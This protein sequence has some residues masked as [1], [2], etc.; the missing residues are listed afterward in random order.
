MRTFLGRVTLVLALAMA[1]GCGR[2]ASVPVVAETDAAPN[3][4]EETHKLPFARE[5][6]PV[7]I[8]PTSSLIPPPA[9]LPAGTPVTI[10]LQTALSS[11]SARAGDTFAAVLD[12][13]IIVAGQILAER[14]AV[15]TGRIIE[16]KAAAAMGAPGYLRLALTT[17]FLDGKAVQISSSSIF[18]KSSS[19]RKEPVRAASTGGAL[20]DS[21]YPAAKT[22]AGTPLNIN[23]GPEHR[24]TFRLTEPVPIH[25]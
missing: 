22:H 18:A 12:E 9:S 11:A 2:Q 15:V 24:L 8:S 23:F 4:A 3:P 6:Q 13:P 16:A 7:G 5:G 14:G 21:A 17:L 1:A 25:G 20:V 10:R 19:R